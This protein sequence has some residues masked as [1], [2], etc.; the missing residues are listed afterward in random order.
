MEKEIKLYVV[1]ASFGAAVY[2]SLGYAK[3][4]VKNFLHNTSF[5]ELHVTIECWVST[6]KITEGW[7]WISYNKRKIATRYAFDNSTEDRR[8][9]LFAKDFA[10]TNGA[11]YMREDVYTFAVN[12]GEFFGSCNGMPTNV[13]F[14]SS[15]H[16]CNHWPLARF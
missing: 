3:E 2:G 1:R 10:K 9:E 16:H 11:G 6:G 13:E 15:W 14:L 4:E 5:D 7:Q 8:L 12:N